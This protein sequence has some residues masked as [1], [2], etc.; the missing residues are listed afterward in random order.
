MQG[1]T[2]G[3]WSIFWSA[4]AVV[5]FAELGCLARTSLLAA[6]YGRPWVIFAGT[7]VGTAIVM[8]IGIAAGQMVHL[9]LPESAT[10]WLTGL[11]FLL[12]GALVLS[13]RLQG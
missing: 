2:P 6:R 1:Q 7:M 9:R 3:L 10:R 13:G 11:F 5:V 12:F 4:V 8:A